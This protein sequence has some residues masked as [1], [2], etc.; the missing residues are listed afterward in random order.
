M[1]NLTKEDV[2]GRFDGQTQQLVEKGMIVARGLPSVGDFLTQAR[3]DDIIARTYPTLCPVWNE[4]L[5]YKSV[6]V[7]CEQIQVPQVI[8][9]LYYVQGPDCIEKKK[10]LE[11]GKYAIRANYMCW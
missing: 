4:E 2:W 10:T 11:D 7:I 6:T 5:P 9:W 8:D 1:K 3:K